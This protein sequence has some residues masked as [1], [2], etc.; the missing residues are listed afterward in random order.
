MSLESFRKLSL[1][2]VARELGLRPFDIARILGQHEPGM[3]AELQFDADIVARIREFAGVEIWWRPD[4]PLDADDANRSRAM[5]RTLAAKLLAHQERGPDSTRADNLFRGLEGADQLLIR[6][7]VN[8]MIREGLLQSVST[9]SGLHV[10]VDEVQVDTLQAIASGA[11]I[12]DNI[13]ALW[14]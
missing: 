11:Q 3:P 13:A 12:P 6:R 4:A 2:D 10:V 14:S 8:Q 7:A 5:V 9:V 1:A